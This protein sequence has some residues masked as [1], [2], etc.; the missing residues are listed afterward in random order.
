M[1]L[2]SKQSTWMLYH[3][4]APGA[5]GPSEARAAGLP[6]RESRAVISLG[7]APSRCSANTC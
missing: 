5:H 2:H 4:T 7:L 3:E 1:N 6:W